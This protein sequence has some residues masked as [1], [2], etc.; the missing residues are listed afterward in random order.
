MPRDKCPAR[1]PAPRRLVSTPRHRARDNRPRLRQFSRHNGRAPPFIR[2]MADSIRPAIAAP[3][4]RAPCGQCLFIRGKRR[5]A[6]RCA[7]TRTRAPPYFG[8]SKVLFP[9]C[10]TME[11]A[12]ACAL[13]ENSANG[14]PSTLAYSSITQYKVVKSDLRQGVGIS[15]NRES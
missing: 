8:E 3:A 11:T 2:P 5:K 9:K 15:A 4:I 7:E 14:G 10:P 13:R 6:Q 1:H 12:P